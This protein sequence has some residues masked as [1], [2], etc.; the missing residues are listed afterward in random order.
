VCDFCVK[1][2]AIFCCR[3]QRSHCVIGEAGVIFWRE[4]AFLNFHMTGRLFSCSDANANAK[5]TALCGRKR[6][7][8]REKKVLSR[9]I[10]L[11]VVVLH[12][13]AVVNAFHSL[14][15]CKSRLETSSRR[16][17][18]GVAAMSRKRTT[19]S[20]PSLKDVIDKD[21]TLYKWTCHEDASFHN[22][23]SEEA[24][25][26]RKALLTWYRANRRKLPWRGDPPPYDGST[27]GF[28][29]NNS[30]SKVCV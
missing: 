6:M 21:S 29:S 4:N 19:A 13:P 5:T 22:F 28:N 20:E 10:A 8:E 9:I 1:C 12:R 3:E 15:R 16:S 25:E 17:T 11:F 14:S 18:H 30:K 7:A 26:I 24:S 27:A 23:S 2:Q